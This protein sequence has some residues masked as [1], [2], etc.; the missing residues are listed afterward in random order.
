MN[1]DDVGKILRERRQFLN[2][3]QEDLAEISGVAI[4]T[5]YAVELGKGNPSLETLMKILKVL[6]MEINIQ[7]KKS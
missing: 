5:I 3:K 1:V 7:T 2:L 4:K 6:G